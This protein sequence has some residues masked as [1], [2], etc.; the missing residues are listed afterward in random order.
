MPKTGKADDVWRA[1]VTKFAV[2]D[3][4]FGPGQYPGNKTRWYTDVE[5]IKKCPLMG[6]RG[7]KHDLFGRQL[8]CSCDYHTVCTQDCCCD[9][10]V[11]F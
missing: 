9:V 11:L 5:R 8:A 10:S 7:L 6:E 3:F 1:R 2:G 4:K